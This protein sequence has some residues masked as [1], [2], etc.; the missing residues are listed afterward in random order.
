MTPQEKLQHIA[1]I[2]ETLTPMGGGRHQS[3]H[4]RHNLEGALIDMER[5]GFADAVS[6][7][8][9]RRVCE[10]LA[11]IEQILEAPLASAGE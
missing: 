8:T 6:L 1:A 5:T 7:R 3:T 10:Q 11:E 4:A 2:Y 9:V